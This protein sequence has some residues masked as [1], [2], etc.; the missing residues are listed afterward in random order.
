MRKLVI[1][2]ALTTAWLQAAGQKIVISG[3]ENYSWAFSDEALREFKSA[4][5]DVTFVFAKPGADLAREIVDA[6]AV[7]GGI[8]PDLFAKAKKLKWVQTFSAGVEAYRWK[9]FIDSPVILTNC[10]IVQGPNIADHAMSMLL[11]LTRGLNQYISERGKEEWD[12][13]NRGLTELQDMTAVIIGVGGIGSQIAQRAHAFGMKVIGVD[14]KDIAP[15]A[16][17]SKMVYPDQLDKVLPMADVVFIAAPLTPQSE[18]MMGQRQF[19][20]LKK[21]SY[22]V[23]VSRGGLYDTAALLN[24]LD[25]KKLAGA[26]L[27]VTNPEPLPKGHALWKF[28]NVIITPH[29]AGQSPGSYNRR[30]GV[31]KENVLRFVRGDRLI[32]V[33]DKQ[34][35][36]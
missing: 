7:I 35:G 6:D 20:L 24:A 23:A 5:P 25:S 22:F 16:N 17:V 12:R 34:K 3:S 2:L 33:V 13:G 11:A 14:P 28:P 15:N 19:D 29:V 18:R 36:Y 31:I 4:A 27:D 8:T 26:G 1:L 21:G 9:E 10:K 32:N 30:V